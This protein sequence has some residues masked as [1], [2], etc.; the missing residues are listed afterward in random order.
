MSQ[1]QAIIE[2]L[3]A[4]STAWRSGF[5][6]TANALLK[7]AEELSKEDKSNRD[8]PKSFVDKSF[9]TDPVTGMFYGLS[10]IFLMAR[11]EDLY[12]DRML[13]QRSPHQAL[14]A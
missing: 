1:T 6:H 14:A 11:I 7:I 2:T 3:L 8:Y 12:V 5:V 9:E 4:A 10:D 13:G